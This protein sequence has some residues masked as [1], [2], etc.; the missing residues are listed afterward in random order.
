MKSI[1]KTDTK[2]Q[3]VTYVCILGASILMLCSSILSTNNKWMDINIFHL[4]CATAG[5]EVR[6]Q[7]T[8]RILDDGPCSQILSTKI[9]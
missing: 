9:G 5:F 8:H 7:R 4:I 3:P 1:L 6:I 2:A